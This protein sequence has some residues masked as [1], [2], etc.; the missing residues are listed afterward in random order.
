MEPSN[1]FAYLIMFLTGKSVGGWIHLNSGFC[2]WCCRSLIL[3]EVPSDWNGYIG[4]GHS[5]AIHF[6]WWFAV[7]GV[8]LSFWGLECNRFS[9]MRILGLVLLESNMSTGNE[10]IWDVDE[11]PL[12][13]TLTLASQRHLRFKVC[14]SISIR[15]LTLV[16]NSLK[17]LYSPR[18]KRKTPDGDPS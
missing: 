4:C 7:G 15:C 2:Y 1:S 10:M 8:V 18:I 9:Q 17:S 5:E 13:S 11:V 16:S 6:L 3:F 14:S 12:H